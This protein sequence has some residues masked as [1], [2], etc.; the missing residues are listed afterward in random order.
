MASSGVTV[1]ITSFLQNQ[2]PSPVD[3]QAVLDPVASRIVYRPSGGDV[4]TSHLLEPGV[5]TV[6]FEAGLADTQNFRLE[7][8]T[9]FITDTQQ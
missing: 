3:F 4:D 7:L 5:Y 9:E 2:V 6:A 1:T 8:E